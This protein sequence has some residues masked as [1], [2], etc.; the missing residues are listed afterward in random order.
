MKVLVVG[1]ESAHVQGFLENMRLENAEFS[2]LLETP[3]TW[4]HQKEKVISLRTKNPIKL[5][6]AY[7]SIKKY[8]KK[9]NPDIVHCHQINRL[10]F[11]VSHIVKKQHVKLIATAWGSDVLLVPQ[12]NWVFKKMV[13][14]VLKTATI[15]TAD[16]SSMIQAME[17][18]V[19]SKNKYISWQYG[20]NPIQA[21]T[22]EKI[23]YSN[24]LHKPLYRIDQII[25]YFADFVKTNSDWTLVIGATGSET[26]NLKRLVKSN[27]LEEK[28]KFVGWLNEKENAE[29]YSISSIY[30]SIPESDGTSVSLMEALSANC[31]PVVSDLPVN[32]EWIV[33]KVNGI[34][35]K[36]NMNPLIESL[37]IDK[38]ACYKINQQKISGITKD[39]TRKEM[40]VYYQKLMN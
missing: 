35:E 22:K 17:K 9:L 29:W 10:A 1:S 27:D 2:F 16:A 20:I 38:E 11:F 28:V 13:Q 25:L 23:F 18:L 12:K 31:I 14:F 4:F 7:F 33:D 40:M 19:P 6:K 8:I 39:K 34:I 26:E 3:V 5:L 21:Q 30:I 36:P 24:R 37:S 32:H 15:V